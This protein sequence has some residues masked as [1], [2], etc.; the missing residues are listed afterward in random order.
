[1]LSSLYNT[2]T[3]GDATIF[4]CPI[5]ELIAWRFSDMQALLFPLSPDRM[6][7]FR[8]NQGPDNVEAFPSRRHAGE[9][10]ICMQQRSPC[11]MWNEVANNTFFSSNV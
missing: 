9:A 6:L 5:V 1:M 2:T 11:I 8:L 7:V 3:T 4:R 10:S